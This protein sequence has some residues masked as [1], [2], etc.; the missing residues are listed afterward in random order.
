MLPGLLD[1]QPKQMN[2]PLMYV[3][4]T[5][6]MDVACGYTPRIPVQGTDILIFN[7]QVGC[8]E[9]LVAVVERVECTG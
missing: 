5:E 9:P 1:C 4:V 6:T 7:E 2:L 3:L 8:V